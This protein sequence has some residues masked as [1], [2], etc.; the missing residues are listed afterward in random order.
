MQWGT[1]RA[2]SFPSPPLP[3]SGL[4]SSSQHLQDCPQRWPRRHS[5]GC[6]FS[7][8]VKETLC[9]HLNSEVLP[10]SCLKRPEFIFCLQKEVVKFSKEYQKET[11][12]ITCKPGATMFE[13][14]FKGLLAL[15]M[16]SRSWRL[17]Q[18]ELRTSGTSFS[19]S[20][21][22]WNWKL[23]Q[24]KIGGYSFHRWR[25]W[26]SRCRPAFLER[27]GPHTP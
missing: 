1:W 19:E 23:I 6:L 14:H 7:T 12:V 10:V 20:A 16:F 9:N 27:M 17:K 3:P 18:H 21:L 24:G 13:E 22:K 8:T 11:F 4:T 5:A 15:Y 26:W 2:F 25:G